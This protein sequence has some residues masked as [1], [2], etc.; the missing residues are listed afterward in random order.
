MVQVHRGVKAA[1]AA[2]KNVLLLSCL[3]VT[4]QSSS[5]QKKL[6]RR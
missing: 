3:A 5:S 1:E 4:A 6:K 2:P